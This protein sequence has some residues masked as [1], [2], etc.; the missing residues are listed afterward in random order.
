MNNMKTNDTNR[1]VIYLTVDELTEIISNAIKNVSSKPDTTPKEDEFIHGI[2]GIA[3]YLKCSRAQ[4]TKMKKDGFFED[5][6]IQINRKI[7][8]KKSDLIKLLKNNN[9]VR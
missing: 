8:I 1:S 5:K 3:K 7:F 2:N 9:H 6:I 4:I